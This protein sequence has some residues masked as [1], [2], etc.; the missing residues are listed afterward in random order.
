MKVKINLFIHE[1][2]EVLE[3]IEIST[4]NPW[5]IYNTYPEIS[6]KNKSYE[7]LWD[8]DSQTLIKIKERE[9]TFLTKEEVQKSIKEMNKYPDI[10]K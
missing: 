5:Y 4:G 9:K 1:N 7:G 10:F 3:I 6:D 2:K 8:E